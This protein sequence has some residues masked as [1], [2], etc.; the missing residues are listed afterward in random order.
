MQ[1]TEENNEKGKSK[2][3]RSGW[4]NFKI[5]FKRMQRSKK[6][7]SSWGAQNK[8]K[9]ILGAMKNPSDIGKKMKLL[10]FSLD[11]AI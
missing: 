8:P 3:E 1:E 10:I 6:C 9:I 11:L 5:P 7:G 2:Q 4:P